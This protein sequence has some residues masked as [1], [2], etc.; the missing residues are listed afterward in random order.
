MP[1]MRPDPN[2]GYPISIRCQGRLCLTSSFGARFRWMNGSGSRRAR[3]SGSGHFASTGRRAISGPQVGRAEP[4]G[5]THTLIV[6]DDVE[7][8]ITYFQV[9]ASC[10]TATLMESLWAS[11]TSSP[12]SISAGSTT[13]ASAGRAMSTKSSADS[14]P[15][16]PM[17]QPGLFEARQALVARGTSGIGAAIVEAF[18]VLGASVLA[19]GV[20]THCQSRRPSR[21]RSW[22]F[23]SCS[24]LS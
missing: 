18:L 8:M 4:P 5:E 12:K 13:R 7:E 6:P 14:I 19:T 21:T 24:V 16:A 17:P 22:R 9:K 1:R 23:R 11:R 2:P 3:K 10:S 15:K 20:T